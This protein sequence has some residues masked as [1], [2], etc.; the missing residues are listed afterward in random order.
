MFA[1]RFVLLSLL[2]GFAFLLSCSQNKTPKEP[3]FEIVLVEGSSQDAAPDVTPEKP[4][5]E[6]PVSESAPVDI[7]PCN[8]HEDC[9]DN[10]APQCVQGRC[11]AACAA[12]QECPGQDLF[13]CLEGH[14]ISKIPECLQDADCKDATR[15]ACVVGR[16]Q[17]PPPPDCTS[18]ADCNDNTKRCVD[19]KC[20]PKPS[21]CQS[22]SDCQDPAR[23]YC[24]SGACLATQCN[25]D[26]DCT[27]AAKPRCLGGRCQAPPPECT[28]DADCT[29]DANKPKCIDGSCQAPKPECTS[30]DECTSSARPRC[31]ANRCIPISG[32]ETDADCTEQVKPLCENKTCV[33][34]PSGT[35]NSRFIDEDIPDGTKMKPGQRFKKRWKLKNTGTTTWSKACG[36]RFQ[37]IGRTAFGPVKEIS[38][39]PDE[40]VAPGASKDL[41]VDMVAPTKAGS[42]R[43]DW[44]MANQGTAFGT[45]VWAQITVEAC[46][47]NADCTN[48]SFPTC[49]GG[50]CIAPE[51][52]A[53]GDCK[54]ASEP[55]CVQQRCVACKSNTD[56][57]GTNQSCIQGSCIDPNACGEGAKPTQFTWSIPGVKTVCQRF[58]NP[59]KYQSCG[60][61]TGI[62]VCAAD[63]H[64]LLAMADGKVVHVGPMWLSGANVGRGPYCVIIQHSKNFY[65]TYGHNRKALVKVGDCVK[66]GQQIAEIGNLGYSGGPH[67]HLEVVEGTPFTGNWKTP[68]QNACQHYRDPLNY[69]KP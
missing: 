8:K 39:K 4:A 66:R 48:P 17:E 67:V 68:F 36:D 45:I 40:R 16:C 54:N 14:C 42:Y 30:D 34:C 43:S 23:P 58:N 57:T 47:S 51:C 12:A 21:T 1:L 41:F 60:F 53:D 64:P 56:C 25:A 2:A 63:G 20:I 22:T 27:D 37:Y 33:A 69:A 52:T 9:T 65:S 10:S 29:A 61:H 49:Q 5:T 31:A 62:D 18:D 38:L 7:G 44:K 24:V 15:S 6:A 46:A 28:S 26:S 13:V 55:Y 32:C 11:R 3:A 50:E 35:R 59:I 19:R